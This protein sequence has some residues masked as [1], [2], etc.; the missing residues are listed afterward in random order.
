MS[1]LCKVFSGWNVWSVYQKNDLDFEPMMTGLDRGRRL[2]IWVEVT[3]AES[4]GSDINDALALRGSQV[5]ILNGE[6]TGLE[7][8]ARREEQEGPLLM[9]DGPAELRFVRFFNRGQEGV[10]P[11]P[12]DD[13]YLLAATYKASA[14]NPLTAG[15][16]PE[17]MMDAPKAAISDTAMQ[18]GGIALGIGVIWLAIKL[19]TREPK[20]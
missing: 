3:A 15:P 14:Q 7:Y 8:A 11:W 20:L 4:P 13:N 16:A 6:P 18:I 5:Q 1:A 19:L 12:H 17:R 9:L 2:K 10:I